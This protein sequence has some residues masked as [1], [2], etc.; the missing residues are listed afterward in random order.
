LHREVTKSRLNFKHTLYACFGANLVQAAIVNLS[1]LLFIALRESFGYSYTQLGALVL[2]NFFTQVLTDLAFSRI[3]DRYGYRIFIVGGHIAAFL[4][5]VIFA[6]SPLLSPNPY[7]IMVAGTVLFSMGGG[8]MEL[9]LSPIV[10]AIPSDD[11]AGAMSLLHSFYA[12]GQMTVVLLTTAG[13]FIFGASAWPWL[14]LAWALVPLINGV[15]FSRV[16]LEQP[17]RGDTGDGLRKTLRSSAG[18]FLACFVVIAMGGASEISL[19]Q[20][21]SAIMERVAGLPKLAGDTIGMAG[22]AL[23]LALGRTLNAKY[24]SR[25]RLTRMLM[26]GSLLAAAC[27][28]TVALTSSPALALVACALC[29]IGVSLLWPGTIIIAADAFPRAGTWLFAFLAAAGDIGASAGPQMMG[30]LADAAPN[31]PA[32]TQLSATLG[33]ENLGLRAGTLVATLFPLIAFAAVVWIARKQKK[34]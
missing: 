23:M 14:I 5:L 34:T 8:L 30:M 12:W 19:S 1:P 9:L 31:F 24:G 13:I 26:I 15:I 22:F 11:K 20:W 21:S 6:A 16:P 29:G 7:G 18:L 3:V 10:N 28:V 33:P 32:L 17:F 27:Y 25:F 2:I 4:G